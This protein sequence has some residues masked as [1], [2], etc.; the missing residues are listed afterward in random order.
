L[1]AGIM[2]VAADLA[3]YKPQTEQMRISLTSQITL[4]NNS[5]KSLETGIQSVATDL[6]QY[7]PKTEE[8]RISLTNQITSLSNT[9]QSLDASKVPV[10][11]IHWFPSV[12]CPSNFLKLNGALVSRVTFAALWNFA[13]SSG[14]LRN[15]GRDGNGQFG[16]GDGSTTFSLPDFRGLTPRSWDDGRGLD[17]DRALGTY[18]ASQNLLHSHGVSDPGHNHYV[19]DPGH[20]HTYGKPNVPDGQVQ[21]GKTP[22]TNQVYYDSSAVTKYATTRIY[23]SASSSNIGIHGD[24]GAETRVQ[25]VAMLACIKH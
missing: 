12:N 25:N 16:I 4:L 3:Q 11:S 19:N 24:G 6:A 8:M 21:G 20:Q 9:A 1:E 5:A 15:E 17:S 13:Q 18:Q 22:G 10:G 23:L 14:N 2:N 7:K